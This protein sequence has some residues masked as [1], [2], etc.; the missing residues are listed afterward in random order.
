LSVVEEQLIEIWQTVSGAPSLSVDDNFF[1]VGG[2]SLSAVRLH[3]EIER[4]FDRKLP[5]MTVFQASTVRQ[6]AQRLQQESVSQALRSQFWCSQSIG[7]LNALIQQLGSDCSLVYLDAGLFE[8]AKPARHVRA[9]ARRC[10]AELKAIQPEGPYFL[11]G[12]CMGGLIAFEMA[13][14]LQAQGEEVASL[15]LVE[16]RL[17]ALMQQPNLKPKEQLR[18]FLR[19]IKQLPSSSSMLFRQAA[20]KEKVQQEWVYRGQ[21][22]VRK[23]VPSASYSG[24][25]SFYF[26]HIKDESSSLLSQFGWEKFVSKQAEVHFLAGDHCS[27]LQAPHVQILA[28]GLLQNSRT[29][30]SC[31][32]KP[33]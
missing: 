26:S 2:H 28:Q 32:T 30:S 9:R 13:L 16:C 12:F 33:L 17:P 25:V 4:V 29:Q 27:F 21:Q 31:L 22:A 19:Q 15:T 6:M 1:E 18:Q 3:A 8:I 10:L 7:E 14:Q 5:L 11:G 24:L 20:F 23:Y